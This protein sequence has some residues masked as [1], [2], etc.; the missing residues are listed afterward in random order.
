MKKNI[1]ILLILWLITAIDAFASHIFGGE[2]IY[3]Y[4]GPGSL[5]N[6]KKYRI[7]LKLYRD[8]T[9]GGAAMPTN[10]YIGV[11]D[12]GT[13]LHYPTTQTYYDVPRTMI[14][15]VP[16]NV[17]PCITGN[18]V[19]D[20]SI[21]E[22]SF[23]V[24]LPNNSEGYICAYETCC[25]IAGLQNTNPA[26]GAAGPGSTYV[27]KIP[28]TNTLPA[29][30]HNSSPQFVT[31]L[32]I[33]CKDNPF[34]WNFSA[35]DPDGDSLAYFFTAAYNRT[36][37]NDAGNVAPAPPAS[38]PP[39]DYPLVVYANGYTSTQPLGSA[40][41]INPI[42]GIIT[43]IA[44]TLGN[45]VTAVIIKEYRNG[46]L[47]GEHR[48]DFILRVQDCDIPQATLSPRG[49]TCDGFTLNFQ[50]ETPSPLIN[51]YFWDFGVPLVTDDTST[52]ANPTFTYPYAGDF[53]LTLITNKN[54][55]CSDTAQTLIRVYPGFF[56][57]F[58]YNG[59]C[60]TNPYQ[61]TDTTKTTYGAV[62]AWSWNFGD[63]STLADTSHI[64]NPQWT[65]PSPST[66]TVTLIVANSKGCVDTLV[67]TV[68]IIDK[69]TIAVAFN[70]T[71]ICI[72]DA[73]QLNAT[74][75]GSFSWTPLVNIVG[76]NTATPTV[77]PTADTWYYVKLT[78]NGCENNDSVHV[79]VVSG[80][81]LRAG[82]D[83]TICLTDNAQLSATGNALSYQW[84]P[85]AT[86]NNP[87]IANPMATPVSALTTYTVTGFIG[88]CS[89]TD[90]VIVAT[91]PYPVA[92]A[93][94]D[95]T[96][97]YN[98]SAQLNA[99]HD[100]SSFFWTPTNYLDN[101][102]ILNPVATPP[103]TTTYVLSSFDTKG[104][105]KPGRDTIVVRVNPK[106][107]AYAG[108][109][110]VVV[111][112]QPLQ[113]Q[114]SGGSSY[115]WSPTTGLN[116]P[117]ISNPVGTYTN[118]MDSIQYKVVVADDIGCA[119][120]AFVKVVVYKVLPTVFVPTAFTPNN[121]GLNDVVA[122]IMV[123]IQKLNYFSIY[124]RWGELVFTTTQN[125]KGWDGTI[126]GRLQNTGVFV[127]MVSAEDY[128]GQKIFL[129]GT[130]TLI[131]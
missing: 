66:K 111:V 27:C 26:G 24:D 40:V 118:N 103:R 84:T 37:A 91:V 34:T 109:D 7:T 58:V 108:K 19:G 75:T 52:A 88:S 54:Q 101:P 71:L 42:A 45:Y 110:T 53:M 32:D 17:S 115:V 38:F 126:G 39:P 96:I 10:V 129:K 41:T 29:N 12:Y 68:D 63:L 36:I 123:G 73:V 99:V 51:S 8:N 98:T 100:G 4:L 64:F 121:D 61:F 105:P 112:G 18:I 77:N 44:P 50:N 6:T 131:R 48:K 127:W 117:N 31:S 82:A 119:D 125:K 22:Y 20:Y 122:P 94:P 35:T 56:P 69:P 13:K 67:K 113:L 30:E 124:N 23:T 116:N 128:S 90:D 57:G 120:S 114:A 83:T 1:T 85:A 104:C 11:F 28:G 21:G 95:Q 59:S 86:L 60:F 87:N 62:S 16:I 46:V 102:N 3:Q 92:I 79:R 74:G 81:T 9:G 70:D 80:V 130:V 78:D 5:S 2:M 25:R 43:G 14:T 72:P 89:T 107:I 33:V 76:A 106:V 49:T 65:Y 97:C 93:G 15:P 55:Q 47:I